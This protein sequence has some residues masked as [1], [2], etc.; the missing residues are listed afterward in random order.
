MH[1]QTIWIAA[2]ML[3]LA[4]AAGSEAGA[5]GVSGAHRAPISPDA[6][7]ISAAVGG[8][9]V[10]VSLRTPAPPRLANGTLDT[11]TLRASVDGAR[12]RVLAAA[13]GPDFVP[14]RAYQS[15]P[16]VAGR[17]TVTGL[18]R[19]AALPDVASISLNRATHADL[20]E[21]AALIQADAARTQ[22]ELTGS[23]VTVA[24]LD[25][26]IQTSHPMLSGDIAGQACFLANGG[27]PGGGTSGPTAED[28]FGHGT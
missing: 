25:S 26:G 1:A 5:T 6:A 2:A 20:L 23:G 3:V 10:I 15:V 19:L 13:G 21:S 22:F 11:A 14:A 18:Q 7:A 27:C 28:D 9:D 16:A 17:A 8:A 4:L 12:A 24:V